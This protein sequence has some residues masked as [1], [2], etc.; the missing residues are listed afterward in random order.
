MQNCIYKKRLSH[1]EKCRGDHARADAAY[2]TLERA[3][4]RALDVKHGGQHA[5]LVPGMRGAKVAVAHCRAAV[6]C[7]PPRRCASPARE[8]GSGCEWRHRRYR[9][10]HAPGRAG[11]ASSGCLHGS[12]REQPCIKHAA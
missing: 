10:D 6:A 1:D 2:R 3:C 4:T 12:R 8:P 11:R 9:R 7:P 5:E